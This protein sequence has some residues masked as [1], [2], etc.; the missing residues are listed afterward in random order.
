[1]MTQ[2]QQTL[3]YDGEV[4]LA[5][6][7]SRYAKVW[8]NQ[9][10]TWGR[11]V[12]LLSQTRR[13]GET[14]DEYAKLPK[15]RQGAI[16]DV[17]GFVGGE[18]SGGRRLAANLKSRQLITLDAD[19]A[20]PGFWTAVLLKLGCA[21]CCYS[22][23]KHRPDKPRLRLVIP[24][25]R[26]ITPAEYPA[27]SKRVAADIG[28]DAFDDTTYEPA[29]MMYWPSTA[30][31]AEFVFEVNDAPWLDPDQVLARYENWRDPAGWPESGRSQQ[32]R[33]QQA[34]RQGDPLA[35]PGLVGA[36]CRTYTIPAA[37]AAYLPEIY[38][39]CGEARFNYRP[40][41]SAGG[42]VLYESKFAFSHHGTDPVGGR[43]VNAF[44]LVRIHKFASRDAA[45]PAGTPMQKLPS[46]A[47][48]LE[49]CSRD[50][51]VKAQLA[52][53]CAAT[54]TDSA[55][56][57]DWTARLALSK[58]GRFADCIDNV[59]TILE[60]APELAG[61]IKTNDFTRQ[62]EIT[63][64]LPWAATPRPWEDSDDKALW[65]YFETRWGIAS[66]GKI[67][68]GL[69]MVAAANAFHPVR[70]YLSSLD[71]DGLPRVATVL[72]DYLG[73]ADSAYVRAVTRKFFAAAVARVMDP[74]CKFD[75]MLT[76][77]G[78]QGIGKSELIKRLGQDWHSDSF[79]TVQGKEACEQL[80]GV[81]I[82][83][84]AELSATKKAE[85]EAVKHFISKREDIYRVA[86]GRRVS[87]F[88]R[89]CVFVGTTNDSECLKDKTG[90]RRF[91][92]VDCRAGQAKRSLWDDLT[93]DEI[94]QLWAEAVQLWR[95]GE[96][97]FL[98][99]EL[100]QAALREQ[101]GH[102][103][104]SPLGG[105]IEEYLQRKLPAD[106]YARSLPARRAFLHDHTGAAALPGDALT[107]S[108]V[109]AMEIWCELLEGEPKHLQMTTSRNI[110]EI[111]RKIPGW[112]AVGHKYFSEPYGR[113]RAYER[114][115]PA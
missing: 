102:L 83:E 114:T 60:N 49:L 73:A 40:G 17:G 44:D 65:H 39:P 59:K 55:G 6:G 56:G 81:W 103:E 92:P 10:T 32:Q 67:L 7:A 97:L 87:H 66:L 16:K 58:N 95:G 1:M 47:A 25:S 52:A 91:L 5:I 70:E 4:T 18:L 84:M 77:V 99:G 9:T 85:V 76:L 34:D 111:L 115:A 110:A 113:Q 61:K 94:D 63:A 19:F 74:G 104:E 28:S 78:P 11:L 13:T 2:A 38:E 42:L 86:Y 15:L 71:W 62:L 90:N 53:G 69:S 3:Q 23:H 20:A 68:A 30:S 37:I 8:Q 108:R 88:P 14:M 93:A 41:S 112:T 109:C 43:L 35:K 21:A 22:T 98:A 45:A 57:Q 31:D 50:G 24:L 36:F 54:V 48:M 106:W 82:I 79:S 29:R 51:R 96:P 107:R 89:Q 101:E 12:A 72:V 80:Q 33:R 75:T 105:M 26:P 46:Y 64:A 100:A 27:V